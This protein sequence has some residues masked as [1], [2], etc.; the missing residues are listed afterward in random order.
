MAIE[1]LLWRENALV[2]DKFRVVNVKQLGR[3]PDS[4]VAVGI[5]LSDRSG[6]RMQLMP[7][8]LRAA[9]HVLN[10]YRIRAVQIED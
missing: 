5:S 8:R 6:R 9:K 1:V 2:M 10:G 7:H 4:A 3:A